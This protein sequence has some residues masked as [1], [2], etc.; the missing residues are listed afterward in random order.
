M[1]AKKVNRETVALDDLDKAILRTVQIN[2][3]ATHSSIGQKIGLST[4]AVRRRL[5]NLRAAGV[6]ERDVSILKNDTANIT[7]IIQVSF[8]ID[9]AKTYEEF[10]AR[11]KA[12][13][14]V[15]HS[16]HV[17]GATDYILIV[18]GPSLEWYE[19]W[20][21]ENLMSD[22]AIQRHDTSVVWSRK[23]FETAVPI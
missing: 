10:D 19:D 8:E 18:Q 3:Q 7:L 13:P 12:L 17:S 15:T 23:K 2:N 6:I 1:M 14:N 16:Y 9:T 4:S 11:M 20:A 21:K 22:A 5:A